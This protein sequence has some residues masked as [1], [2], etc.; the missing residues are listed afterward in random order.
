VNALSRRDG[1]TATVKGCCAAAYGSDVV[2][3]VLGESY[4]PGGLRLTRRLAAAT[5]LRAG[6]RVLD[7]A[8][9]PGSTAL[10]LATEY[11]ITVDGVDLGDASLAR[12]RAAAE[13]AG[14]SARVMFRR[15]DAERL[16]YGDATFDA[17]LCECAFCTFPDKTTA[18]REFARV[19]TPGG[20]VGIADV[21]IAGSKLPAELSGLAGWI[22]CL[23]DARP[24]EEYAAL[25]TGAGLQVTCTEP[26][27]EALTRMIE[28]IAARLRAYRITSATQPALADVD[29]DRALELAIQAAR[30][31]EAGVLGYHLLVAEK[32]GE[33]PA[34]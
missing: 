26:H 28:Q 22:A 4:H 14:L 7:V 29:F 32:P 21:T 5:G 34:T 1:E 33:E 16:P 31:A 8:S 13:R 2:A 17:V 18:A 12:A 11:G 3:L 15:A 20:R 25:L 6:Q 23:A 10:L 19:L 9:G 24:A 27:D 30:A